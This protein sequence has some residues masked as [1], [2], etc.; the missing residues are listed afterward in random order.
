MDHCA[1][2][3]Q[4]LVCPSW[5]HTWTFHQAAMPESSG[6]P[7][8]AMCMDSG[9]TVLPLSHRSPVPA[10]SA[11]SEEATSTRYADWRK[12][13]ACGF[14]G[15]SIQLR[16]G[17][18]ASIPCGLTRYSQRSCCGRTAAAPNMVHARTKKTAKRFIVGQA[19]WPVWCLEAFVA[20]RGR[21]RPGGLS[22]AG[23]LA[24]T[25]L[26]DRAATVR[27]R[28]LT[29]WQAWA[30]P[31]PRPRVGGCRPATF[32]LPPPTMARGGAARV[33]R[34]G[35]PRG[36]GAP[37]PG[38]RLGLGLHGRPLLCRAPTI[39]R[40]R[41]TKM[42]PRYTLPIACEST[43]PRVSRSEEHTSELQ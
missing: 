43:I 10:R 8:Y 33:G 13:R 19:S 4:S 24:Y 7:R 31:P 22:T 5:S 23:I 14:T 21:D 16:R 15:V 35:S 17:S 1:S 32:F 25:I 2:G 42:R 28:W 40:R 41:A 20:Q 36:R 3:L 12:A 9:D 34:L 39:G 37:P 38:S 11:A 18:V 29:P 6:L 30:P 26:P 27:E